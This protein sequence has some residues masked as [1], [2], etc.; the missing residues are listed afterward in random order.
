MGC[1]KGIAEEACPY[2]QERDHSQETQW[3]QG[4][5]GEPE[6]AVPQGK[7]RDLEVDCR[8]WEKPWTP[9]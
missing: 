9:C 5:L 8:N 1:K 3:I 4:E 6:G 2:A 7:G